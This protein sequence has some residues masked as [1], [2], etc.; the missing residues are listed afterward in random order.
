MPVFDLLTQNAQIA[1]RTPAQWES[2]VR[3]LVAQ[4]LAGFVY[5]RRAEMLPSDIRAQLHKV[6][7]AQFAFNANLETNYRR[8]RGALENVGC[9]PVLLKGLSLLGRVYDAGERPISDIDV[10]IRPNQ[11]ELSSTVLRELGYRSKT[12]LRWHANDFKRNFED[13]SGLCEVELHTRLFYNEPASFEWGTQ[14]DAERGRHLSDEHM[15]A[16]LLGHL[17]FQHTFLKLFWL[18][19]VDLLARAYGSR[20]DWELLARSLAR[21]RLTR[22]AALVLGACRRYLNTP[23][24]EPILG[25]LPVTPEWVWQ[26]VLTP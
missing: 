10:L 2:C 12:E 9:E 23:G 11:L 25:R 18:V 5:A 22:S 3:T 6:Y 17:G 15:L 13:E 4:G 16:H 14:Y 8:V 24:L 19:D 1:L 7:L 21:L 20:L 26:R